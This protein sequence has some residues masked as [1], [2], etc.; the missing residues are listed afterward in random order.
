MWE[1]HRF[2]R[3]CGRELKPAAH[4]CAN[5]GQSVPE[6]AGQ[7]AATGSAEDPRPGQPPTPDRSAFYPTITTM[8]TPPDPMQ[9]MAAGDRWDGNVFPGEAISNFSGQGTPPPTE[10]RHSAGSAPVSRPARTAHPRAFRWPF[11]LALA[12][13][14]A[15]G[16]TAAGL[17]LTRHS[18]SQ[19]GARGR[20]VAV[21]STIGTTAPPS[22]FSSP[23]GTTA[24]PSPSVLP[25]QID[26]QGV[27][28]G[29][30]AVNTDPDAA[31][32]A[33]TLGT[34][35]ASIDSRNYMQAWDTYT[36]ALQ[37]GSS[38]Q[39]FS[40][41]DSTTQDSQVVVQSIKH[42]RN[43]DLEATVT[44]Q[45]HQAAQYGPS[46]GETC[47]NW[48]LD[49]HLVPSSATSPSSASLSYLINKAAKVGAGN[50][51]C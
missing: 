16:G 20:A 13:L 3:R 27:A 11:A 10:A 15:A 38:F 50:T 26:I 23:A 22:P 46:Q 31:G 39:F 33:A 5:C 40:Q 8:P 14:V 49:Y 25:T 19:P 28:I 44:F 2:C 47:N 51:P 1:G 30:A 37:A 48:T 34:Y 7:A 6:S 41:Q 29:I 36:P 21:S 32:V 42:D 45:S 4:F 17:F 12:V 43:G 35:F 9:P 24:S 18:H